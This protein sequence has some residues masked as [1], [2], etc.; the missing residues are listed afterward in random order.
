MALGAVR[1]DVAGMVLKEA[2]K[3]VGI[4]LVIGVAAALFGAMIISSLLFRVNPR[5]PMVLAAA[6]AI[7]LVTGLFAAWWP[8]RRAAQVE[9]ME[10][11]RS[12]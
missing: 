10:V 8:A 12:N 9:P 1:A 4:C 7:M 3:L 5:D 11:L 6:S 2:G